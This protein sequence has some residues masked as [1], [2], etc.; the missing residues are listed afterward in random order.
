MTLVEIGT[1]SVT[2][3]SKYSPCDIAHVAVGLDK[4]HCNQLYG[5]L[6][7]LVDGMFVSISLTTASRA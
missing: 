1:V 5:L 6:T 7:T 4:K 3:E 2:R